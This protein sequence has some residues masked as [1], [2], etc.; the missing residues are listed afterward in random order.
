VAVRA[1]TNP[2]YH[3]EPVSRTFHARDIFAPAAAHLATGVGFDELGDEVDPET[4]VRITLPSPAVGG[5]GLRATVLAVDRFGNLELNVASSHAEAAGLSPGSRV[6]LVFAVHSYYAAVAETFVDA[7]RGELIL[8]ENAY[9][10]FA[11][12]INGG[13]ASALTGA[14][15]GEEVAILRR[16]E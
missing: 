1:L 16:G 6:E 12:A 7:K 9:G 11:I 10:A 4:L 15:V 13:D 2:R 14:G 3:L 8:Y 5:G